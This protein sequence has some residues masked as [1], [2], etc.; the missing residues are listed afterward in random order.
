M[1]ADVH[2]AYKM[3][4]EIFKRKERTIEVQKYGCLLLDDLYRTSRCI[5]FDDK[6]KGSNM[7]W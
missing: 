6:K 1:L 5:V 7:K 3:F 2:S 4:D